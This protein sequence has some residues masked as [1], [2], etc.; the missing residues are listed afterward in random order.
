[1]ASES[2][3]TPGL[4]FPRGYPPLH[5]GLRPILPQLAVNSFLVTLADGH[6]GF[7]GYIWRGKQNELIRRSMLKA[8]YA[9]K[10]QAPAALALTMEGRNGDHWQKQE[11]RAE[12]WTISQE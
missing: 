8:E 2:T 5:L 7:N 11:C 3:N 10:G 12:N 1:M 6:E 4:G 9:P